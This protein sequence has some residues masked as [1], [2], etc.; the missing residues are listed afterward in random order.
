[1]DQFRVA[2]DLYLKCV[3]E[4]PDYAPAWARLGRMHRVVGKYFEQTTAAGP[5]ASY[6]LAE[7]AF[8]RALELSPDLPIAHSLLTGLEVERGRAMEA[9]TRLIGQARRRGVAPDVFAGLVLSCRYCGLLEASIAA[10]EQARRLDPKVVTSVGFSLLH[11]GFYERG[12]EVA[13]TTMPDT[14]FKT[15]CLLK[16]GRGAEAVEELEAGVR[17]EGQLSWW[18]SGYLAIVRDDRKSAVEPFVRLFDELPED[19]PEASYTVAKA[20]AWLGQIDRAHTAL[21]QGVVRGYYP[22]PAMLGDP[23]FESLQGAQA[24]T[25]ILNLANDRCREARKAYVAS[26]GDDVLG[27]STA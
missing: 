22:H 11:A 25:R 14:I 16:L 26:G 3:E 13:R 2:R 17:L 5:E 23:W 27:T 8:G 9:M 20:F 1:M 7:Q 4:D 19:D 15:E 18:C 12:T 10:D 21:E 24:F 6:Q